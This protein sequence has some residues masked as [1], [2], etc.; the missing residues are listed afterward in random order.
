MNFFKNKNKSR[1]FTTIDPKGNFMAY[2]KHGNL[3]KNLNT[4]DLTKEEQIKIFGRI[5]IK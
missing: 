1:L 2:D 3:I 5:L 4:Y